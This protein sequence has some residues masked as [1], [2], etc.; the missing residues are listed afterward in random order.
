MYIHHTNMNY[1]FKVLVWF[2]FRFLNSSISSPSADLPEMT[3]LAVFCTL[4]SIGWASS[5]QMPWNTISTAL[6]HGCF[7]MCLCFFSYCLCPPFTVFILSKSSI[8][9]KL[10]II[11]DWVFGASTIFDQANTCS[12]A[13]SESYSVLMSSLIITSSLSL[14]LSPCVDCSFYCLFLCNYLLQL[15]I[16]VWPIHSSAF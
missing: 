5:G 14:S 10:V 2:L 6:I 13:T 12:Y 11:I 7:G 1:F 3:D 16:Y 15:P 4:L 9:P 8:S